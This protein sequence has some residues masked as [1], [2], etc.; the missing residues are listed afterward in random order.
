MR[1]EQTSLQKKI[2]IPVIVLVLAIG[3]AAAYF[4][5]RDKPATNQSASNQTSTGDYI[6]LEPPTEDDK[7]E[8]DQ[9][10]DNLADEYL[11]ANKQNPQPS[12]TPTS[13]P[14]TKKEATIVVTYAGQNGSVI[15]VGSYINN[16]Y[17]DGGICTLTL[18]KDG[19]T[20][21]KQAMGVK[22]VSKTICPSFSVN[23]SEFNSAGIWQAVVSYESVHSS[24]KTSAQEVAVQ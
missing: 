21:T 10:K 13:S 8:T 2:I 18:T 1:S 4:I 19:S 24:G 11:D 17:E 15:E 3:G 5:L 9:N 6:N 16:V 7:K 23:R 20:I 12:T 22:D 14:S